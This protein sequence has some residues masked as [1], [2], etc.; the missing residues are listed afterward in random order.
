[1]A[2]K[3]LSSPTRIQPGPAEKPLSPK[4]WCMLSRSV[5]PDSDTPWSAA[6]QAPLFMGILQVRILEW[7]ALPSSRGSPQARD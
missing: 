3:D 2:C 7:V 1:M 6:R 4:H 5:M